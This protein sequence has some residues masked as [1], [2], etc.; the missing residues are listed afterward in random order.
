MW[1]GVCVVLLIVASAF[2]IAYL[3]RSATTTAGAVRLSLTTPDKATLPVH[4]TV[5]PDGA[6][7]VFVAGG[8][9]GKRLLWV[10]PLDSL[11]AQ[12]LAGT[13][14]AAAPFWSPD[15]RFI[16][17]F[18]G[19]KLKKI[20][21]TGGPA[22]TLCDAP[23]GAG[24]AWSRDNVIVFAPNYEDAL[25]RV[26]AAGGAPAR[27]TVLD[28]S[29]K[30]TAHVRPQFL[31]DG[32]HF[33]YLTTSAQRENRGIYVGSLDSKETKL[34][35]NTYQGAAYAPPG[36]LLFMRE[37]TLMAQGLDA[38]RLELK[39]EPFPVAEQ[40]DLLPA[41]TRLAFFSVSQTGVLVY[42]SG[43]NRSFQ[44]TWFDRSGKQIGTVGPPGPYFNP[45]LSPDE[46]RVAVDRGE[47][48]GQAGAPT[49][50]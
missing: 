31:P 48:P 35:V 29:R 45:S 19:G 26:P 3:S 27:V 21:S 24:G 44:L 32:R 7:I 6:R 14:G 8:P 4:I 28:A 36:Y 47:L 12:P 43:R 22:Q 11:T 17:F 10:R 33:I 18:S 23:Q 39:G 30:E 20:D 50:G 42:R 49:S 46:K 34:L 2:A 5:S 13:D 1:L 38:D 15:S 9:D 40:V 41:E 16:G 37:R 25:Y